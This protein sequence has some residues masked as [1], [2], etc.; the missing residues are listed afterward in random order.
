MAYASFPDLRALATH[1]RSELQTKKF[2]LLYAYNGTG[3]TR[4]SGA[5]KDI[6]KK[7]DEFGETIERDT[8]YF[9]AF[10]EDLFNWENDLTGDK[11][12]FLK[13]NEKSQ[14]LKALASTEFDTRIRSLLDRYA[15]FDFRINSETDKDGKLTKAEV[16]FFRDQPK[17]GS[18]DDKQE[19]PFGIG[20]ISRG[21]ESVFIWC[22]FLAILQL[23]LDGHVDYQWV[24][25]FIDD[26]ISSLDPVATVGLEQLEHAGVV[27]ARLAGQCPRHLIRQVVVADA[28]RVGVAER[29]DGHLGSGPAP[30]PGTARSRR[31]PR[32]ATGDASS[33]RELPLPPGARCRRAGARRPSGGTP[34][35]AWWPAS[36]GPG[37]RA[38]RRRRRDRARGSPKA[39][40]ERGVGAGLPSDDLLLDDRRHRASTTAFER[41]MRRPGRRR[42]RSRSTGARPEAVVGVVA[43][44]E[45]GRGVEGPCRSRPPRPH[46][47]LVA[48]ARSAASSRARRAYGSPATR[49]RARPASTGRAAAP[50]PARVRR[51]STSWGGRM[52]RSTGPRPL[53]PCVTGTQRTPPRGPAVRSSS[54]SGRSARD[55]PSASRRPTDPSVSRRETVPSCQRRAAERRKRTMSPRLSPTS[56]RLGSGRV[57]QVGL[58]RRRGPRCRRGGPPHTLRQRGRLRHCRCGELRG[59]SRAPAAGRRRG[60]RPSRCRPRAAAGRG[61]P[62]CVEPATDSVGHA[63]RVLDERL[64]RA[65]RLGQR[66]HP[67]GGRDRER[68][69]LAAAQR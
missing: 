57:E 52:R 10:T 20:K 13:L 24:G 35:T 36:A 18:D 44:D 46:A 51:R 39:A 3:K 54:S 25:T 58:V 45:L 38:C 67:R 61:R 7:I 42:C 31:W 11:H 12:R 2:V 63:R 8:L 15:D 6:G 29:D 14:Y 49:R 40:H 60:R 62:R 55:R 9:N 43:T 4:L 59:P 41:A 69:L 26:P 56:S 33:S 16:V 5:F 1:L 68:R 34:S 28:D 53:T 48:G 64:D 22:F 50:Q 30:T 23:T 47:D 27:T 66:E 21:E 32:P 17:E 65:E 19:D 37:G